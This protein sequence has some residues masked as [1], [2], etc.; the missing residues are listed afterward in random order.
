MPVR[1]YYESIGFDFTKLSFEVVGK[2][3]MDEYERRKYEAN[4]APGI[5]DVL[6][7]NKSLGIDQS[8]LSAYSQHT[9]EEVVGYFNLKEYFSHIVGLDNIY[10]ASKLQQG[11]DLIKKIGL[12][13]GS[14]L[15]IGDMIH[16]L[17]VAR[18]IGADC[19]LLG[20]GHQS[21]KNLKELSLPL[22][23]ITILPSV[24]KLLNFD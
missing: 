13:G 5:V 22:G 14:V 8:I 4:L 24:D 7:K 1:S 6:K 10:A 21:V 16:D 12:D 15:L 20:S 3:W 23:D 17:E 9:L 18:E 2:E 19:I 11:K